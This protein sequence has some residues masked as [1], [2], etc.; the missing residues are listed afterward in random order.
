MFE[1]ARGRREDG[2]NDPNPFW[3]YPGPAAIE[4]HVSAYPMSRDITRLEALRRSL[5]LYQMVFGQQ[6]P[7]DLLKY[8]AERIPTQRLADLSSSWQIDLSPP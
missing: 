6:R 8:L 5:A 1:E 3:V 2:A 7:E 4:R